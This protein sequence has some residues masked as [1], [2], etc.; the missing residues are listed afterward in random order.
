M[1][2]TVFREGFD[3][4]AVRVKESAVSWLSCLELNRVGSADWGQGEQLKGANSLKLKK[5]VNMVIIV[6]KRRI[7]EFLIR[8]LMMSSLIKS[9]TC[10]S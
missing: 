2:V 3:V 8:Y 7:N 9:C 10:L 5:V 4:V 1:R 6:Y